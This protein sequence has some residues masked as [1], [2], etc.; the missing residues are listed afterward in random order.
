MKVRCIDA[1]NLS[2]TNGKVYEV[3]KEI[4]EN[5]FTWYEI[6]NDSQEVQH[7]LTRRFEEVKEM[8]KQIVCIDVGSEIVYYKGND[9]HIVKSIDL[10]RRDVIFTDGDED[11]F[12]FLTSCNA[13][14]ELH[15][16]NGILVSKIEEVR[17]AGYNDKVTLKVG[18]IITDGP[19]VTDTDFEIIRIQDGKIYRAFNKHKPYD[20]ELQKDI[21]SVNGK[22]YHRDNIIIPDQVVDKHE[23]VNQPEQD[24]EMFELITPENIEE[25]FRYN[26]LLGFEYRKYESYICLNYFKDGVDIKDCQMITIFFNNPNW[27]QH[28]ELETGKLKPLPKFDFK[29]Y[30]ID[31]GFEGMKWII[32]GK[33]SLL[34]NSEN[35][36]TKKCKVSLSGMGDR[37]FYLSQTKANAD[38]LIAMAKI[39]EGLE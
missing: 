25:V 6:K 5:S 26:D 23:G 17:I 1:E 34:P 2:I 31:N 36:N 37:G 11:N 7:Y 38:R 33:L 27:L 15:S 18:D 28:I 22:K 19:Y 20:F 21:I 4:H 8:E 35:N 10:D 39:A 13:L 14:K 16:I 32:R 3:L 30:L 24:D 12:S 9:P 29:Q